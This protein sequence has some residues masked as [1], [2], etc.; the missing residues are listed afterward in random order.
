MLKSTSV[1]RIFGINPCMPRV[2]TRITPNKLELS[3]IMIKERR[4][5]VRYL[6]SMW[7]HFGDRHF[8]YQTMGGVN[9]SKI[10]LHRSH[11]RHQY[12]HPSKYHDKW[13]VRQIKMQGQQ[14][15]GFGGYHK[16]R[17]NLQT[18]GTNF[19]QDGPLKRSFKGLNKDEAIEILEQWG[20]KFV[21]LDEL[22]RPSLVECMYWKHKL[23]AHNFPWIKNPVTNAQ[24]GDADYSWK[25]TEKFDYS[26]YGA[27]TKSEKNSFT[28]LWRTAVEEAAVITDPIISEPAK[29]SVKKAEPKSSAVPAGAADSAKK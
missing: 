7:H 16:D 17:M 4:K 18:V 14:Y 9:G 27:T 11:G 2:L 8:L 26:V 13:S 21:V 1:C 6:G 20:L 12:H 19:F 10:I 5:R 25:G 24:I 28:S 29:K 15:A 3:M 22:K 23:Y